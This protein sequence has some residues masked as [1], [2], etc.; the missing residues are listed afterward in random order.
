L[1][2][3]VLLGVRWRR[4]CLGWGLLDL[5]VGPFGIEGFEDASAKALFEFEQDA[6][7][8]EVDAALTGMTDPGETPD[9]VLA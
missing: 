8:G 3:E 2:I 6:D 7:A 4:R 9:I 5:S 1:A